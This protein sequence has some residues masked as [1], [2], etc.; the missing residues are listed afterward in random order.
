MARNDQ[1]HTLPHSST[2]RDKAAEREM[3]SRKVRELIRG[4]LKRMPQSDLVKILYSVQRWQDEDATRDELFIPVPPGRSPMKG[5]QTSINVKKGGA[6]PDE[7]EERLRKWRLKVK[8]SLEA[9][10][11]EELFNEVMDE[12]DRMSYETLKHLSQSLLAL[13]KRRW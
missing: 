2:S 4:L 9:K 11:Q 8:E 5:S 13:G 6:E 7:G 1:R 12:V 10:R 3:M